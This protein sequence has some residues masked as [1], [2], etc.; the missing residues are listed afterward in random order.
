MT[1]RTGIAFLLAAAA[2]AGVLYSVRVPMTPAS[3]EQTV[4]EVELAALPM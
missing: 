1:G 2:H 4:M 3:Q